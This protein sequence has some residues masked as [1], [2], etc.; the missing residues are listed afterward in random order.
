MRS[1]IGRVVKSIFPL[2]HAF[3]YA[4]VRETEKPTDRECTRRTVECHRT[5]AGE[6]NGFLHGDDRGPVLDQTSAAD[7]NTMT[8][9]GYGKQTTYL[10][11]CNKKQNRCAAGSPRSR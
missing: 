9:A 7:R 4:Y 1:H 10:V 8:V 5:S 3:G 2:V 6:G 11:A